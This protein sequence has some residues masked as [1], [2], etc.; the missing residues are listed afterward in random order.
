[1]NKHDRMYLEIV[2]NGNALIE[3]FDLPNQDPVALSKKLFR[4][5]YKAHRFTEDYCN[6]KIETDQWEGVS[7]KI[8]ASL[9]KIIGKKNMN[10][11]FVNGDA[12]G[13][14]LKIDDKY[15]DKM[16][17]AGITRDFG[18]YGIIAPDFRE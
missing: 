10:K 15:R 1:M 14:A 8:L 5:E 9:E 12:R 11:V 16:H 6:G 3:F 7:D 13:Y 18:G 2:K 17:K 4:L